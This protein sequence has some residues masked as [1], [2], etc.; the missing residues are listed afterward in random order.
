MKP[1]EAWCPGGTLTPQDGWWS[2]AVITKD[3]ASFS[4]DTPVF[5]C[6]AKEEMCVATGN[7]TPGAAFACAPGHA[8]VLCASCEDGFL[9][10]HQRCQECTKLQMSLPAI[11][12]VVTLFVAAIGVV[13]FNVSLRRRGAEMMK[14][15]HA[16][17]KH[18]AWKHKQQRRQHRRASLAGDAGAA[19]GVL[20]QYAVQLKAKMVSAVRV[21]VKAALD[22]NFGSEIMRITINAAK[23]V[24]HL[25]GTLSY[26]LYFPAA[27]DGLRA[28]YAML[29]IDIF[30]ESNMPC[31]FPSFDFYTKLEIAMAAPFLIS[32]AVSAGGIAWAARHH[33]H[34][35]R[36]KIEMRRSVL[37]RER[38][39]GSHESTVK[40]G[41]W[42]AA[43]ITLFI[44]D[45]IYPAVTRTLLEFYTCRDLRT[46]PCVTCDAGE[47]SSPPGHWLEA[48][49]R[50]MLFSE[51]VF[52]HVFANRLCIFL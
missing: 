10:K 48:D 27:M 14:N 17:R 50:Y 45:L 25:T 26:C 37:A 13:F 23:V 28:A 34:R 19:P 18:L 29:A 4:E 15:L 36:G 33:H 35:R 1:A 9:L 42:K 21:S 16:M 22:G 8:G 5:E 49:Y 32:F 44:L 20:A 43:P 3:T 51:P 11:V 39:R 2:P 31:I 6:P 30:S 41:L 12:A 47:E 52:L 7:V 38:S 40:T 46:G 24:S